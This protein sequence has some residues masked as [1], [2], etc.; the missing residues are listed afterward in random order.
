[1]SGHGVNFDLLNI[2]I[3]CTFVWR[4]IK[5]YCYLHQGHILMFPLLTSCSMYQWCSELFYILQHMTYNPARNTC[6]Q[7][8]LTSRFW[9]GSAT[10]FRRKWYFR[11]ISSDNEIYIYFLTR[12]ICIKQQFTPGCH[13]LHE[14]IR[15]SSYAKSK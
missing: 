11:L 3:V 14:N 15:I 2:K 9:K 13:S 6:P 1:M 7:Q 5:L 10:D 12:D 8:S 4:Y